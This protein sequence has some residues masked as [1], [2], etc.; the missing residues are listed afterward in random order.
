M[1]TNKVKTYKEAGVD[2]GLR[3]RAKGSF[4]DFNLTFRYSGRGKIF[5]T[6]FNNLYS[7]GRGVYQVK[8]AD[9]VGTKVLLAELANK[10]NTIGIDAVAMVVNDCVRCGAK[11]LALT[12]IIDIKKSTPKLLKEIEK[13]LIKGAKEAECPIVGGETADV[14]EILSASY[15]LNCDCVGEVEKEKIIDGKKIKAGDVVLGFRSSGVH[16]NG[17]TL[18]RKVLF[19]KWSGRYQPFE[20]PGGI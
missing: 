1:R 6:P 14:P 4:R 11:P 2:R 8:T 5:K 20:K 13:G 15:H 9:G 10:H 12:D 19:K 17:F 7:V 16:S 18:L 3:K